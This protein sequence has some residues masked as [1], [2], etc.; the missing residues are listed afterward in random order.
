MVSRSWVTI[1]TVKPSALAHAARQFRRVFGRGV[2]RQS[3]HGE[4]EEGK[5]VHHCL[6]QFEMLE[7]RH[8]DVL[9][10]GQRGEQRAVLEQDAP[11][12]LDI[13]AILRCQRLVVAAEQLDLPHVRLDQP[14]DDAE[15]HRLALAGAA[16]N[17]EDLAAIDVEIEPVPNLIAAEA[18]GESA[19]ADQDLSAVLQGHIPIADRN[20]ANTASRIITRKIALTTA[21]VTCLP[22]DS[23]LPSTFMPSRQPTSPMISAANGALIIPA[24]KCWTSTAS[25]SLSI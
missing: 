20:M 10:H 21:L 8:L 15:Q 14:G 7:H 23:A 25:C 13:D 11:A 1:Y 22:R 6:R 3:D 17:G 2:W 19:D 18:L 5:V 9:Q 16:D 24:M 12:A 4:L